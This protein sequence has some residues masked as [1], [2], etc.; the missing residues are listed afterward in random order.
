MK[1]QQPIPIPLKQRWQDFKSE[2]LPIAFFVVL[3]ACILWMW[4]RYVTPPSVIGQVE[5]IHANVISTVPGTLL[6]LNTGLLEK[7]TNGQC[8]ATIRVMEPDVLSNELAAI[9]ADMHLLKA[10]MD[11][12]RTRNVSTYAAARQNLLTERLNLAIAEVRKVQTESELTRAKTLFDA[13]LITAGGESGKG[14]SIGYEVALRDRDSVRA[15]I[16]QR[17][18]A[19]EQI[20]KNLKDLET[21]GQITVS[22][23]DETIE[24]TIEAQTRRCQS[25]NQCLTL[26][27]PM[28][29]FISVVNHRPG[30]KV[31]AGASILV[32]SAEKSE[33]VIAWIRQPVSMTPKVGDIVAIRRTQMGQTPVSARVVQVG[34]QLEAIDQTLMPPSSGQNHTILGLPFMVNLPPDAHYT[35]GEPVVVTLLHGTGLRWF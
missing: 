5:A 33:R 10:R 30:E 28:N 32:V 11:I 1:D 2:Y 29:G 34:S 16:E 15:E 17:N 14:G 20:E 21:T 23:V 22:P 9:E 3:C 4:G 18:R 24:K 13:K 35:P 8:V 7:V 25:I 19:I 12:D 31:M 26:R 6:E 27:A